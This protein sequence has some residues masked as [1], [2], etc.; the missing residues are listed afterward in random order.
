MESWFLFSVYAL[1]LWGLW[2]FLNK[3]A[4]NTLSAKMTF[5]FSFLGSISFFLIFLFFIKP[6]YVILSNKGIYSAV[7]GGIFSS[8]A[9]LP[10]LYALEKGKASVVIPLTSL[11]PLL[12]LLLAFFILKEKITLLQGVGVI[13][14]LLSITLFSL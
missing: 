6:E 12:S 9:F 14:A 7:V 3:I 10:F 2:G 11:Y 5:I 4:M 1:L 13:L 8:L